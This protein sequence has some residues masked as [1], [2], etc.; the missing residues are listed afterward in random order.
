[1]QSSLC[2]NYILCTGRYYYIRSV[3]MVHC[4]VKCVCADIQSGL[5]YTG[6]QTTFGCLLEECHLSELQQQP[7]GESINVTYILLIIL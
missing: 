2:D 1:M 4:F 5:L 7:Q 3:S 6:P